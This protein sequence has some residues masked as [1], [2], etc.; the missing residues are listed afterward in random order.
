VS[1]TVTDKGTTGV[2]IELENVTKRYSASSTGLAAVDDLT[3]SIPAGKIVVL[4][5]PSGCGKTTTMRLIN[6]LIEPTSGRIMIGDTDARAQEP[7][8]LRRSIG[9]VI[10]QA[11]LFPHMTVGT[12]IAQVPQMLGW[13]K[14]RTA[15][16][17]DELL[18]LVGL[19]VGQFRDRY[20]RQLSGGQQQRVGVAR[21]LAADPSV[22]LMDEPFGALDP[23]TRE[24]L[25]DEL[26]RLQ[27][28]LGKTIVFVTHD[29]D[30][31]L[32]IGDQIAIL[33]KGSSIAQYA[34][35]AEILA[36]PASEYVEQF[37]GSGS[38]MRLLNF[39]KVADV[40][41]GQVAECAPGDDIAQ[42][43][44]TIASADSAYALVVEAGRKP[45][46]WVTSEILEGR[47]GTAGELAAPIETTIPAR[48]TLQEAMEGLLQAEYD[49]VPVT[50]ANGTYLGV[51]SLGTIQ[52]ELADLKDRQKAR[53]QDRVTTGG[54]PA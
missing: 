8:E 45:T 23:I 35:P 28:E 37:I 43:R 52:Q 41:L 38:A 50:R 40:E 2:P 48:A 24:R 22:L 18:E 53:R 17:V 33:D 14:Q 6:R 12:N 7:N 1:E 26:L 36:N 46:G 29:I 39:A 15:K 44:E 20:P 10:Q 25:Q 49:V 42:V 11:G 32:R 19:D 5:G 4:L 3:M 21:A 54:D 27:E 47:N 16:R 30:E 51:V 34:S 31:A 13:D 9:Y